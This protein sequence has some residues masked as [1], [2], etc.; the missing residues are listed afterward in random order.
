MKRLTTLATAL[1]LAGCGSNKP[2]AKPSASEP[3]VSVRT[4]TAV[5][6]DT[7]EVIEVTGS[8]H[9]E[10]EATL[11]AKVLARVERVWVREGDRVTSGQALAGLDS[12]D[13]E[14]EVAQSRANLAGAEAGYSAA[15]VGVR[16][17]SALTAAQVGQAEA[18]VA[19][20]EAALRTAIAR[21]DLVEAGPRSQ[22]RA[23]AALATQRAKLA[24]TQA[25]ADYLR[26]DTLFKQDAVS[27]QQYELAKTAYETAQT[28]YESALQAQS[29][30]EEGSRPEEKRA[31]HEAVSQAQADLGQA[32]AAL[33]QAQAGAIQVQMRE[34]EARGAK[35]RI[36]QSKAALNQASVMRDYATLRAPFSGV[37]ALRLADPGDLAAPGVPLLAV[38]GGA[39]QLWVTVPESALPS[40]AVGTQVRPSLDALGELSGRVREI[41]PQGDPSSHTFTVKID[42]IGKGARPGMFGR[43]RVRTAQSKQVMVPKAA[44]WERDGLHFV[45]VVSGGTARARVVTIGSPTKAGTPVLSGLDSGEI[46]VIEPKGVRDGAKVKS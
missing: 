4:A 14:A 8:V 17:D 3:P 29:A 21:R 42:T 39:T 36:S 5:L 35:T 12:K 32:R 16:M 1:I 2:E 11:S 46:V 30:T 40:L 26:F 44:V 23:A 41:A 31:A 6:E 37:V 28:Q 45:S 7:P 33:K 9:P 27:K 25:R 20:A 19:Q 24:L 34:Q 43:L 13:L 18:K 22:E 15:Q 10:L 38:H